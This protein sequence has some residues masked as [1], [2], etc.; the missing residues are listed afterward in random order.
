MKYFLLILLFTY[1]LN[2]YSQQNWRK[3]WCVEQNGD[4]LRG[5]ILFGDWEISPSE[6]VFRDSVKLLQQKFGTKDLKSFALTNDKQIEL[7]ESK[8]LRITKFSE[9]RVKFGQNA[10]SNEIVSKFVELTECRIII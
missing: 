10:T 5:Q 6:I 7:F 3:G 9:G 2:A 8:T 1:Q 4:T